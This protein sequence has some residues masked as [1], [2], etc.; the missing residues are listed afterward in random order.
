MP[1]AIASWLGITPGNRL[2]LSALGGPVNVTWP[3]T[4]AL[5][6]SLGSIRLLIEAVQGAV[7]DQA[8]ICFQRDAST[9]ALSLIDRNANATHGFQ[10]LSLLTGI[11]FGDSEAGFLDELGLALGTR[12]TR[13]SVIDVLKRR[14]ESA[15]AALV[16]Q[17][18]ESAAL[19]A[20]IEALK[21][22]F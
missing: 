2:L 17:E 19:D 18:A 15:L 11:P 13:A 14:G 4:S 7:G 20:A 8:L 21:E 16:P 22:L 9:V 6:A 3:T 12:G 5:G 10:R 1:P